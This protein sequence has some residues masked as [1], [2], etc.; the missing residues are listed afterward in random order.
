MLYHKNSG[1]WSLQDLSD[2]ESCY[3][4]NEHFKHIFLTRNVFFSTF[5]QISDNPNF[6]YSE[7]GPTPLVRFTEDLMYKKIYMLIHGA[8]KF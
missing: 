4:I 8:F 7:V 5:I 6:L 3:C 2:Y 1:K